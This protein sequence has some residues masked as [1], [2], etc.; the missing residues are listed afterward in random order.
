[1]LAVLGAV[2]QIQHWPNDVGTVQSYFKGT[3]AGT[4]FL[5]GQLPPKTKI[6]NLY[7][8]TVLLVDSVQIVLRAYHRTVQA[9]HSLLSGRCTDVIDRSNPCVLIRDDMLIAHEQSRQ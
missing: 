8:H 6:F 7:C 9:F 3:H 4:E 5:G 1:M 2:N